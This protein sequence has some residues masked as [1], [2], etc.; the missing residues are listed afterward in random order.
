LDVETTEIVNSNYSLFDD[1]WNQNIET[2]SEEIIV[3][4]TDLWKKFKQ[5]NKVII[6]EMNILG[7]KFK[8]YIKS[9]VPLSSIILR[10]KNVNSAFDIKGICLKTNIGVKKEAEQKQQQKQDKIELEFK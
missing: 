2:T 8:D 6:N 10:N 4:S 7:D 3:T 9:K 5:E 1:W